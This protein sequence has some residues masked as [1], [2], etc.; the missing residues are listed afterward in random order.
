MHYNFV[1]DSL[2]KETM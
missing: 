1:A 2:H